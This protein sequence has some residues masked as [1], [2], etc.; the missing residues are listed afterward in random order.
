LIQQVAS[1]RLRIIETDNISVDLEYNKDF[2][3]VHLPRVDKFNKTRLIEL[4]DYLSDLWKF[5][6]T[7]GYTA[8]YAATEHPPTQ[9]LAEKMN[10][11]YIGQQNN[12]K[13]Y[14][15]GRSTTSNFSN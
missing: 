8:L 12:L 6:S 13:V 4:E 5:I 10:F 1:E 3:I 9:K 15:Y 7:I 11:V 14:V 2:A